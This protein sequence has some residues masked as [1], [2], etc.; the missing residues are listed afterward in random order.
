MKSLKPYLRYVPGDYVM[1]LV[2]FAGV[3]TFGWFCGPKVFLRFS[4][5]FEGF[6]SCFFFSNVF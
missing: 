2:I 5:F 1:A 3:D 6:V 4:I